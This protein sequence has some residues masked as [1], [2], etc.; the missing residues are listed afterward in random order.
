MTFYDLNV[1]DV[2][3]HRELP[4]AALILRVSSGGVIV[5]NETGRVVC[6]ESG[7]LDYNPNKWWDIV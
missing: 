1:G 2:L 7:L 5:M 3:Y 4:M 6:W